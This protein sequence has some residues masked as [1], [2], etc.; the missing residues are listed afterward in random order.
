MDSF[1]SAFWMFLEIFSSHLFISSFFPYRVDKKQ[2]FFVYIALWVGMVFLSR[3]V[4]DAIP[5]IFVF[6]PLLLLS[7][8]YLFQG[9]LPHHILVTLLCILAFS[10]CDTLFSYGMCSLLSI[11]FKELS[12]RKLTYLAVVTIGKLFAVLMTWLLHRFRNAGQ[13]QKIQLQWLI[14]PLLFPLVSF[15]M[16]FIVYSGF[17]DNSDLPRGAFIFS[18][19]LSVANIAI[20]YLVGLLE[21]GTKSKHEMDLLNQQMEIQAQSIF[22]LEKS[23]RAQRTAAHEFSHR[24]QTLDDLLSQGEYSEAKNYIKQIQ[25]IQTTRVFGINARHPIIDAILNSKYQTAKEHNIDMQVHVNNLSAVSLPT[26]AMVV[27][28]ANLLDNAI[29]ACQ[30]YS[31]EGI[32]HCTLLAEGE[33]FLSI[34]NTSAPVEIIDG[35]IPTSK[36]SSS[37]HGYGLTNIQHILRSLNAEFTFH[38]ANGWFH[39]VAEIPME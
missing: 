10:V 12:T 35:K 2:S 22:A 31:G 33:L 29:E 1:V 24:M 20:I 16:L 32:I 14:L 3:L 38:Y 17:Q 26:D 13:P 30:R 5:T 37:E 25:G 34:E 6:V 4:P 18:L 19:A 21:K 15:I 36:S 9:S 23:Y 11:S 8:I 39:F 28:L 7:S 27:L